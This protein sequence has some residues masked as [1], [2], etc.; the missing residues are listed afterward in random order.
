[1]DR[2]RLDRHGCVRRPVV[3]RDHRR[4]Q[5]VPDERRPG[6]LRPAAVAA[7]PRARAVLDRRLPTASRRPL[8]TRAPAP[9]PDLLARAR[10]TRDP[11]R[12]GDRARSRRAGAVRPGA[13][14]RSAPCGR[15]DSCVSLARVPLGGN[16]EPLRV[17]SLGVLAGPGRPQRARG[18]PRALV[19]A[20]S[21][22][23]ACAEPQG[24]RR[25]DV[26]RARFAAGVP[27]PAAGRC[28][29]DGRLGDLA[30]RRLL[31]DT[32]PR[33]VLRR[34]RPALCRRPRR[35]DS[36][37]PR[38]DAVP[39]TSDGVGHRRSESRRRLHAARLD[40]LPRPAGAVLDAAR[41]TD[42]V[43]QRLVRLPAAARARQPLPPGN[44]HRLLRRRRD[45]GRSG[46]PR[47][48]AA[49]VSP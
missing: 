39:S 25:D 9:H 8:P 2:R 13:S 30:R 10:R 26:H 18:I 34:V 27:R 23:S 37:C 24:G 31:R 19:A 32:D 28:D 46:P 12:P 36:R 6:L 4:P 5:R 15:V 48:A 3:A 44:A 20:G 41:G 38:L 11:H 7:V 14:V 17:P 49:L 35:L 22:C 40:R 21:H 47:S 16:H 29:R 33:W 1:M 43:A 45:R 42:R